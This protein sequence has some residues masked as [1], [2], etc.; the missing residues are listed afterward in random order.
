M[1]RPSRRIVPPTSVALRGSS[2]MRARARL[3]L[4]LPDSPMMPSASPS[5]RSNETPSTARS[6]PRC[7]GVLEAQ[8]A[9]LEQRHQSRRSRG[10][11][12]GSMASARSMKV[13]A[14]MTMS[15]PGET[16]HHQ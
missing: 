11:T 7:R 6:G 15:R 9:D 8:V 3:V 13:T 2:R 1:S 14:V 10:L 12:T 4:P 5:A 16:T